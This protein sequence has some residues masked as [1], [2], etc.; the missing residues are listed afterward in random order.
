M[1]RVAN[2]YGLLHHVRSNLRILF[3]AHKVLLLQW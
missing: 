3:I 1:E 2:D